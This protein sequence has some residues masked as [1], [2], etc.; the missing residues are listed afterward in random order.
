MV[1][2]PP[3]AINA[4]NDYIKRVIGLPGEKVEMK[5][6]KVYIN[7]KPLKEPYVDEALNYEYGP[8]IVPP[9]GLFVMGDNRN[10]SFDSHYWNAWLTQ[11]RLKGKA[12]VTYW[13]PGHIKL[14]PRG[15]SFE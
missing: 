15:V 7:D 1:F 14:L 4:T 10:H 5:N 3:A 6:G 2:E 11:D 13:P 8:V 9:N 12:F